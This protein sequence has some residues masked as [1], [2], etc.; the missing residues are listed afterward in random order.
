MTKTIQNQTTQKNN[1]FIQ[2]FNNETK[3]WVPKRYALSPI[4]DPLNKNNGKV[5]VEFVPK[6]NKGK[7]SFGF[8]IVFNG[9]YRCYCGGSPKKLARAFVTK[10]TEIESQINEEP[11][12]LD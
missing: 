1:N 9:K 7:D 10:I 5:T 11:I 6:Y 12:Y 4:D 8:E 2:F 3:R